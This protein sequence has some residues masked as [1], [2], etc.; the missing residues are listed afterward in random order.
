MRA[1]STNRPHCGMSAW[2]LLTVLGVTAI[3]GGS[4]S[5]RAQSTTPSVARLNLETSDTVFDG[6]HMQIVHLVAPSLTL[7]T[8]TLAAWI[9]RTGSPEPAG[10]VLRHRTN[11]EVTLSI[12]I[13]DAAWAGQSAAAW[14]N[15]QDEITRQL[16]GEVEVSGQADSEEGPPAIRLFGWRTREATFT[17]PGPH[18]EGQ[19]AEHHILAADGK[20]AVLFVLRGKAATLPQ[21]ESDFRFFVSRLMLD[22]GKAD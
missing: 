18:P 12:S 21:Y 17:W 20:R 14:S 8:D 10:F 7:T 1:S 3:A 6:V 9:P 11:N 22:P 5:A 15:Y 2:C 16:G 19:W 4:T 13:L